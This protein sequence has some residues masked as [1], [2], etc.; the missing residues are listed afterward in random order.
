[1]AAAW[2]NFNN[3]DTGFAVRTALNTFNTAI[4]LNMSNAEGRLDNTESATAVNTSAIGGLDTRIGTNEAD[5]ENLNG[6]VTTLEVSMTE[7]HKLIVSG[8]STASSQEPSTV[9]T[10]LQLEF[11]VEQ[12]TE[13]VTLSAAGSL[14]FNVAGKYLL[15]MNAQYGRSGAAGISVLLFRMQLDGVNFGGSL[16]A[17][18]STAEHL[19]PWSSTFLVNATVGQILTTEIIRDSTG[20][21]S[22]GIFSITPTAAGW[23]AAACT[24]LQVYKV[25]E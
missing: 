23:N 2:V 14:T 3:G 19:V 25:G 10:P 9:D 4:A 7:C 6:R 5:V 17:K 8:T 15:N 18:I 20:D 21:N 13:D 12:I 1:M 11:G 16:A 22:G 24:T